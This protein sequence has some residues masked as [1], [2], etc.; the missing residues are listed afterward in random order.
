MFTVKKKLTEKA[1]EP[2]KDDKQKFED[3]TKNFDKESKKLIKK[4][5]KSEELDQTDLFL[6]EYI[7]NR[8]WLSSKLN[9]Q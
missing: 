1:E 2:Q 8:K 6:K 9:Q 3:L 7:L 5:W 4:M